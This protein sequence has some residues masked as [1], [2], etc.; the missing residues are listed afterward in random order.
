[1]ATYGSKAAQRKNKRFNSVQFA[2]GGGGA[3][4]GATPKMR[5]SRLSY[6]AE[7]APT[8]MLD[9][10]SRFGKDWLSGH[11]KRMGMAERE[12]LNQI[13]YKKYGEKEGTDSENVHGY[14]EYDGDFAEKERSKSQMADALL[15]LGDIGGGPRDDRLPMR[16]PS[17]D[18]GGGPRDDKLPLDA[19][20]AI[21]RPMSFAGSANEG[22]NNYGSQPTASTANRPMSF[23]SST[24]IDA[25]NSDTSSADNSDTSAADNGADT[26]NIEPND[27][28]SSTPV[29]AARIN[30]IMMQNAL[31]DQQDFDSLRAR[32]ILALQT[33]TPEGGELKAEMLSRMEGGGD[34]YSSRP[35]SPIQNA[36]RQA[37]LRRL[38][39]NSP[40]GSPEQAELRQQLTDLIANI[41]RD[42]DYTADRKYYE[43]SGVKGIESDSMDYELANAAKVNIQK[44]DEIKRLLDKG[45]ASL[46]FAADFRTDV[47]RAVSL[48]RDT[49][50]AYDASITDKEIIDV[51]TGSEVFGYIKSLGIGARGM[52]TA[53]ER[54]FML[55][56]LTGHTE[57]NKNTLLRMAEI[58]R[59]TAVKRISDFI[60]NQASGQY[61]RFFA[62]S[63]KP[64][65]EYDFNNPE[66]SIY[67]D[68]GGLSSNSGSIG[69]PR[70]NEGRSNVKQFDEAGDPL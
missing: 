48:F 55:K 15:D 10:L 6:D 12:A 23:A 58:R 59:K 9:A 64:V 63:K 16:P 28:T 13:Y 50:E 7:T 8:G 44:A 49:E 30:T 61:D 19:E 27:V 52:D 32:D 53:E 56:V 51:L 69:K 24:A 54:R 22:I 26:S 66:E 14:L 34:Q 67:S 41:G 11:E 62:A 5:E 57:L 38:I 70:S 40:E 3:L 65:F 42:L 29:D 33:F 25:D 1:M 47:K 39:R 21:T 31:I 43:R 4:Y 35:S 36:K 60:K 17:Y 18:L 20:T 46:G 2:P 37:E 68:T 45:K